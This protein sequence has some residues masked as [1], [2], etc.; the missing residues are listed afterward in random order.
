CGPATQPIGIGTS[1]A[2]E[3]V[4]KTVSID[5]PGATH[6]YSSQISRNLSVDLESIGSI[7]CRKF[8]DCSKSAPLPKDDICGPTTG[9]I[10]IGIAHTDNDVCKAIS[11][12]VTG[13]TYGPANLITRNPSIDLKSIGS[14]ERRKFQ[15][16]SKSTPLPKDDIC[17]S[18]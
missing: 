18:T 6:G 14:I 4:R 5:V 17:G 15:D 16:C 11:V 1:C 12:D 13:R 9:S 8:Q 2:D 3:D 10:R 7:Q